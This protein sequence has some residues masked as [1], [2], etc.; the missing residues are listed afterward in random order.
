MEL[1]DGGGLARSLPGL[2][3]AAAAILGTYAAFRRNWRHTAVFVAVA[4]GIFGVTYAIPVAAEVYG[5]ICHPWRQPT[6]AHMTVEAAQSAEGI[7]EVSGTTDLPDGAVV[8]YYFLH[9]AEMADLSRLPR[10]QASGRAEVRKGRFAVSQDLSSW[11]AG[12]AIL[13]VEFAVGVDYPQPA[14]VIEI[15]GSQGECL[16][17]PQVGVDSPGDPRTLYTERRLLLAG[18]ARAV[19]SPIDQA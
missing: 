12:N 6:E 18:G 7:V 3:L 13:G 19:S 2:V 14:Q 17:G 4:L 9:E 10:Y 5:D 16:A 15:F 8:D 11:P 1:L